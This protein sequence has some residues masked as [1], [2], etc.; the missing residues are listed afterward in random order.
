MLE[1]V[2]VMKLGAPHSFLYSFIQEAGERFCSALFQGS[3]VSVV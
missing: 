3:F 2:Q 1:K